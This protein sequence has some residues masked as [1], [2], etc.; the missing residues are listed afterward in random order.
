MAD[1]SD[2]IIH[3][4]PEDFGIELKA[5][6]ACTPLLQNRSTLFS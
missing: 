3:P 6:R 1:T 2:P 4:K 5:P